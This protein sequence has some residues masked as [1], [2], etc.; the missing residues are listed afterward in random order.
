[1]I[2]SQVRMAFPSERLREALGILSPLAER[3]RVDPGCL[4]CHVYRDAHEDSVLML[5]EVWRDEEDLARHLRSN[6]YRDVLLLMEMALKPPEVC[7]N[8]V[9][10]SAGMEA[11]E[12]ARR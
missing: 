1:M 11:I 4:G 12:R 2:H 9:S 8:T 10:G 3:V 7:F 6:E 5:E